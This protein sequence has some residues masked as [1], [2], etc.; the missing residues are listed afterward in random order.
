MRLLIIGTLKGQLSAAT[1]IAIDRG[2]S[3]THAVDIEQGCGLF[4]DGTI[5]VVD[6]CDRKA[7]APID[8]QVRGADNRT[9][10]NDCDGIEAGW[11]GPG[12]RQISHRTRVSASVP[13]TFGTAAVPAAGARLKTGAICAHHSPE[14]AP[15]GGS[16]S[17]RIRA[18]HS[19]TRG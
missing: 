17:D 11:P 18:S 9:A 10:A 12:L 1:K 19:T 6:A 3:V 5:D 2:A 13:V 8:G 14:A 7:K 15:G 4:C 16:C